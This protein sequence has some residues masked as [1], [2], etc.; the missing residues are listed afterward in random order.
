[1]VESAIERADG[2]VCGEFRMATMKHDLRCNGIDSL[3]F[4]VQSNIVLS[5]LAISYCFAL[6][7]SIVIPSLV[8]SARVTPY[9]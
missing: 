6:A 8:R 1:M 4:T 7:G 2:G 5:T 9:Q 3:E